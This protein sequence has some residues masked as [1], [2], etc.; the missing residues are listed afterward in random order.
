MRPGIEVVSAEEVGVGGPSLQSALRWAEYEVRV[1]ADGMSAADVQAKID[2]L[3]SARSVPAEHKREKKVRHYDLRPL[4]L[5]LCLDGVEEGAYRLRMR[6][7]AEQEQTARADQA[8]LALGL[9]EPVSVHRRRLHVEDTPAVV[10][11]FRAARER[12]G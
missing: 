2:A 6:L 10:R 4:V 8:V 11:A 12:G 1:P 3:I 7:R 9:P 5:D